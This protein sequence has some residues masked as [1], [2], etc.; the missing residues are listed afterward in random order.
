MDNGRRGQ[1][2]MQAHYNFF[3]RSRGDPRTD[4]RTWLA[5][6]DHSIHWRKVS[7]AQA[8]HYVE[9]RLAFKEEETGHTGMSLLFG[10]AEAAITMDYDTLI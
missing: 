8:G 4:V 9:P 10:T 7:A 6:A 5:L 2:L 1:T 3:R